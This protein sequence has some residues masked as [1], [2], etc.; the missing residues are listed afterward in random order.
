M[1]DHLRLP[2]RHAVTHAW[3]QALVHSDMH[4]A[5][6]SEAA[7]HSRECVGVEDLPH[8]APRHCTA[9]HRESSSARRRSLVTQGLVADAGQ[10]SARVRKP[11]HACRVTMQSCRE[12][13]HGCIR[14]MHACIRTYQ[15]CIDAA[16]SNRLIR[17]ENSPPAA[18][19]HRDMSL[20]HKDSAGVHRE[21]YGTQWPMCALQ[22]GQSCVHSDESHAHEGSAAAQMNQRSRHRNSPH[23]HV[24]EVR[25]HRRMSGM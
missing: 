24:L 12:T 3:E 21:I 4:V 13:L 10:D 15:L 22:E 11:M 23:A 1:A 19:L 20:M 16:A 6:A 25:A 14:A 7:M 8:R 5:R 18:R 2:A 9:A 17:V